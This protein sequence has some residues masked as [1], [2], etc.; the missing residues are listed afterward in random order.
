MAVLGGI[1]VNYL[2]TASEYEITARCK[3]MLDR[4]SSRG[5]YALGSGNSIPDYV[6]DEKYFALLRAIGDKQW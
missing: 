5:G 2:I 4:A 3:K 6:P 1:D